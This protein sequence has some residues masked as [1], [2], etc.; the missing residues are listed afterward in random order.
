[1]HRDPIQVIHFDLFDGNMVDLGPKQVFVSAGN[2][3]QEIKGKI[4]KHKQTGI[5][6]HH[7]CGRICVVIPGQQCSGKGNTASQE[8]N[9]PIGKHQRTVSPVYLLE[10][11]VMVHPH[12]EDAEKR[13][14]ESQKRRPCC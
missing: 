7:Y 1:M 5:N 8:E 10:Y 12:N 3:P 6:G 13:K 14:A 11:F 2:T 9:K 4:D